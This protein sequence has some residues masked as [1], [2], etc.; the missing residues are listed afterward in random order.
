ML[1]YATA[2]R[3]VDPTSVVPTLERMM[4]MYRSSHDT[5]TSVYSSLHG[6]G[7]S[8]STAVY[9]V[10]KRHSLHVGGCELDSVAAGLLFILCSLKCLHES[11]LH[12]CREDAN[13]AQFVVG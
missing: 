12:R 10:M 5:E 11:P 1:T 2:L 8:Q 7:T 13:T 6:N 4:P 3:L 9:T